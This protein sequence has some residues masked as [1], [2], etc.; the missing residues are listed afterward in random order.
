MPPALAF[1]RY[2]ATNGPNGGR[3]ASGVCSPAGD[4]SRLYSQR[5]H[6]AN[7]AE[8]GCGFREADL[9]TVQS[10]GFS[11]SDSRKSK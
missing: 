9:R 6:T 5:V 4:E 7:Q 3:D 1:R 11:G 10:A 8:L 2:G